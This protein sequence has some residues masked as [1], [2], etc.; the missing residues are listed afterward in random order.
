MKD[1]ELLRGTL[2]CVDANLIVPADAIQP[3]TNPEGKI[4]F[5]LPGSLTAGANVIDARK[6]DLFDPAAE[7]RETATANE[8]SVVYLNAATLVAEVV[9]HN[10]DVTNSASKA[11]CAT[12]EAAKA[13][14]SRCVPALSEEELSVRSE[15]TGKTMAE[16]MAEVC[17]Q[18]ALNSRMALASFLGSWL[19]LK[20]ER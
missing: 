14:I 4:R 1:S 2:S 6:S 16:K 8:P 11:Y 17:S 19:F 20:S 5:V 12:P 9:A 18:G 15:S 10:A 13:L 3:G 7:G